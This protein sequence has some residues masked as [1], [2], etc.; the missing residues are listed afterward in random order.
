[1]LASYP[2]CIKPLGTVM[3]LHLALSIN[4]NVVIYNCYPMSERPRRR[5]KATA[6]SHQRMDQKWLAQGAE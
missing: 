2:T 3:P 5:W 4:K 1:M 6:K